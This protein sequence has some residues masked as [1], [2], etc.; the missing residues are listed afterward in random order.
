LGF[1][2]GALELQQQMLTGRLARAA[3]REPLPENQR[4]I[5]DLISERGPLTTPE[6]AVALRVP[7]RTVRYHLAQLTR[8]KLLEAPT[9]KAG[10]RYSLPLSAEPTSSPATGLRTAGEP[11]SGAGQP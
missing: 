3:E 11:A 2:L 10:R 1:F 4:R 6:I 8:W 9:R 5:L 7:A